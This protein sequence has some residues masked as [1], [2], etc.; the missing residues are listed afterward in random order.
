MILIGRWLDSGSQRARRDELEEQ[1]VRGR[2]LSMCSCQ[3]AERGACLTKERACGKIG[4]VRS[5]TAAE[6]R[7]RSSQFP[8][9]M[10]KGTH[11]FPY[12]T[13]KL[14]PWVPM[15]LGWRRPGRVGRCRIPNKIS[16]FTD[17]VRGLVFSCALF[18]F[19]IIMKG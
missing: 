3:G 8:V 7:E 9:A 16:P 2:Y 18:V 17:R 14:S 11:L 12:R 6:D 13:Q 5:G 10:T 19:C 15:V 4:T 1:K